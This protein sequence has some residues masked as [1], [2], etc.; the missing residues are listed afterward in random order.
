MEYYAPT[1]IRLRTFNAESSP[2]NYEPDTF[3]HRH[4]LRRYLVSLL[5]IKKHFW[6]VPIPSST[7]DVPSSHTT[8]KQLF[9]FT[10]SSPTRSFPFAAFFGYACSD[11]RQDIP[12][13]DQ[14]GVFEDLVRANHRMRVFHSGFRSSD[15]ARYLEMEFVQDPF[16]L[17]L[18]AFTLNTKR[19]F[20]FVRRASV[21]TRGSN[22]HT[23]HGSRWRVRV[24]L[25]NQRSL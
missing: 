4:V 11:D 3:P 7:Y 10:L 20:N 2:L 25:K 6:T 22:Q 5:Q 14:Q 19:F 12:R 13:A 18:L 15:R 8:A 21:R 1:V 17:A 24:L 9:E 16:V 23:Y